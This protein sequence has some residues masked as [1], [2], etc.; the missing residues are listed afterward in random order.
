MAVMIDITVLLCKAIGI[1]GHA[2]LA[3]LTVGV[4]LVFSTLSTDESPV[5]NAG[6]RFS[7][8]IVGSVVALRSSGIAVPVPGSQELMVME[9]QASYL[10]DPKEK[11]KYSPTRGSLLWVQ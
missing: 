7:G 10:S 8:V 9:S 3:A 4:I 1:P 6:L 11:Y 2:R 5:V